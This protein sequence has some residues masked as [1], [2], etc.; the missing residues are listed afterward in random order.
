MVPPSTR[1]WLVSERIKLS[2]G[3]EAT[4]YQVEDDKEAR[5]YRMIETID[6]LLLVAQDMAIYKLAIELQQIFLQGEPLEKDFLV[7]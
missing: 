4:R 6:D 2:G 3:S 7:A 1:L 5:Y